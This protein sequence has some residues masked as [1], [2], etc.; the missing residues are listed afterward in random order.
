MIKNVLGGVEKA[1][2]YG[3]IEHQVIPN[4]KFLFA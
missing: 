3:A 4:L 1:N 2:S